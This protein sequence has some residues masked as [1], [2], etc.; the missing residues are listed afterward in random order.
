MDVKIISPTIAP[1]LNIVFSFNIKSILLT[2]ERKNKTKDEMIK[3]VMC[4]SYQNPL[5][6]STT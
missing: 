5:L 1:P 2:K 3:A 4:K 6:L